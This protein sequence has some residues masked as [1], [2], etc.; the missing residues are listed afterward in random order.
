[1]QRYQLPSVE[2]DADID[3]LVDA[4]DAVKKQLEH[5]RLRYIK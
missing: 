5:Q 4:G 1:M 3:T 2:S